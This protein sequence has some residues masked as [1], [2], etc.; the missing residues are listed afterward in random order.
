VRDIFAVE[1]LDIPNIVAIGAQGPFR[2]FGPRRNPG[3]ERLP[4][5]NEVVRQVGRE[6][7]PCSVCASKL[8]QYVSDDAVITR[9]VP[10]T[11]NATLNSASNDLLAL[12]IRIT[13][14]WAPMAAKVV[15]ER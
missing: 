5:A 6:R 12:M 8:R 13:Q 3:C 15:A 7:Q 2:G 9:S 11:D 10:W 1:A 14:R 4:T